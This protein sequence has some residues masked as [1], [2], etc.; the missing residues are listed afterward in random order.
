M[1]NTCSFLADFATDKGPRRLWCVSTLLPVQKRV[2]AGLS[3]D[4]I[5]PAEFFWAIKLREP[6]H[7]LKSLTRHAEA[8]VIFVSADRE[9]L[10]LEGSKV[11][12][13]PY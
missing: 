3:G 9:S 5:C 10:S 7:G 8:F 13:S 4:M 11:V 6:F 2:S 12:N 1:Q